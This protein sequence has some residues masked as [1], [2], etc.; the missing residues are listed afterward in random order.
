MPFLNNYNV[1]IS[2]QLNAIAHKKVA[3]DYNVANFP[4]EIEP[5]TQHEFQTVD[6]PDLVGGN[7]DLAA[8]VMDL[9]IEPKIVGGEMKAKRVIKSRV[10]KPIDVTSATEP[11]TKQ[12][13]AT[14]LKD[15]EVKPKRVRVK[16]VKGGDFSDVMNGIKSAASAVGDVVK[17]AATV[18]PYV[19]PLIGLGKKKTEWNELVAKTRKEKGLSLKDTLKYIKEHN[20]YTKKT[21]T[22]TKGG[23]RLGITDA[24]AAIAKG[25]MEAMPK[26]RHSVKAMKY[27]PPENVTAMT[28]P[29]NQ[30]PIQK[31]RTKKVL[32]LTN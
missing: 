14:A 26:E 31:K 2:Q 28:L 15:M 12:E 3:H 18:A 4:H 16:K 27:E 29:I 23:S 19:A 24:T 6:N 21:P 11:V 7:G 32:A 9:G 17:T 20:L 8:T 25:D 22:K 1:G 10:K 13:V 5:T 30:T